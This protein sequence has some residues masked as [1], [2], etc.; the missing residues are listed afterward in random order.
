MHKLIIFDLKVRE[1][2]QNGVNKIARAVGNTLGP[3]GTNVA[4]EREWGTPT[5]VHDGVTVAKEINLKD[6]FENVAAQLVKDAAQRTNDLAGDGTTTSVILTQ[7]LVNEGLKV[8]STGVSP[9]MIRRGLEK[10]LP[11]VVEAFKDQAKKVKTIEQKRRIASVAAGDD[12]MGKTIADT[13][14]KVGVEGVV[15]VEESNSLETTVEYRQGMEIDAGFA[16]AN[17]ITNLERLIAEVENPYI[18]LTDYT[19]TSV[20]DMLPF[21]K[22]FSL[23]SKQKSLVVVAEK[24]EGSVL[25]SM[26]VTKMQ[27]MVA[28]IAVN[29]PGLGDDRKTMLQ[30]LA[31]LTGATIISQEAGHNLD[32]ITMDHL[33]RCERVISD[34]SS[35]I[36]QGGEGDPKKRIKEIKAQMKEAKTDFVKEKLEERLAKLSSGIAVISVGAST[37]SEMKERKERVVDAVNATKAAIEEGYVVGGALSMI[38]AADMLDDLQLKNQESQFGVEILQKAL[39]YPFKILMDNANEDHGRIFEKILRKNDKKFGYNVV[40]GKIEDLVES[41]VIDPVKVVR[42]ALENA[43]SVAIVLLTTNVI[44]CASKED[45]EKDKTAR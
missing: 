34:K 1:K 21:F 40:T 19:L 15:T 44:I 23:K 18:L 14:D 2:L 33:G 30:D 27:G 38:F 45:K 31:T 16:S 6:P 24:V 25:A 20:A 28:M 36:F 7:A 5:V 35:T 42:L 13:V 12:E 43:V 8:I 11:K 10:A 29:A 4:L 26:V 37:V 9:M 41:G 39:Y 3:K 32:E 17:F 22:E